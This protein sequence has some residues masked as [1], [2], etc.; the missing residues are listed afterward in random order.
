MS[1]LQCMFTKNVNLPTCYYFFIKATTV[2]VHFPYLQDGNGRTKNPKLP[3]MKTAN[4]VMLT[5][6]FSV[7]IS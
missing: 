4:G 6:Y 3:L 7:N 5:V 1:I 2:T